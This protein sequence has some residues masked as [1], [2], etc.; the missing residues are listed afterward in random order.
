VQSFIKVL[1]EL[2]EVG[3]FSFGKQEAELFVGIVNGI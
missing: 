3:V 1:T 2:Y